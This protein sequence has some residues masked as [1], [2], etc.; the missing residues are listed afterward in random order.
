MSFPC[1]SKVARVDFHLFPNL[2]DDTVRLVLSFLA[3]GTSFCEEGGLVEC[4]LPGYNEKKRHEIS[5]LKRRVL[6]LK[7]ACKK[8]NHHLSAI[9]VALPLPVKDMYGMFETFHVDVVVV[10]FNMHVDFL[11]YFGFTEDEIALS[12][13]FFFDCIGS[14]FVG[15]SLHE[16][17]KNYTS[18]INLLDI[19]A[20]PYSTLHALPPCVDWECI[21]SAASLLGKEVWDCNI[22][23]LEVF[24]KPG[25]VV[26]FVF[27][28]VDMDAYLNARYKALIISQKPGFFLMCETNWHG[29]TWEGDSWSQV[30]RVPFD[31]L[32][33]LQ[34]CW[35]LVLQNDESFGGSYKCDLNQHEVPLIEIV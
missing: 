33:Q 13:I 7:L 1:G 19:E 11:K 6:A 35:G 29:S 26:T 18:V 5:A 31:K 8:F 15:Q 3:A 20:A 10:K 28:G 4:G 17:L 27:T 30:V 22:Q 21:T 16:I 14:E 2:L 25:H 24:L 34:R 12:C 32:E 23:C 9:L